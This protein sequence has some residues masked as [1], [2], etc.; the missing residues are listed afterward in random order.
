[1][2]IKCWFFKNYN[3]FSVEFVSL[4]KGQVTFAAIKFYQVG[5]KAKM[6][7]SLNLDSYLDPMRC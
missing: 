4:S 3:T 7:Q 2:E 5:L 6:L 1:M